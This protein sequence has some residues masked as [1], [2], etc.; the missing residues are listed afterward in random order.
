MVVTPT[1][2]YLWVGGVRQCVYDQHTYTAVGK[3]LS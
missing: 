2:R 3:L 1:R